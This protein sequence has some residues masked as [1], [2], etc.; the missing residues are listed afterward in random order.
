MTLTPRHRAVAARGGNEC[1]QREEAMIDPTATRSAL[2]KCLSP[3]LFCAAMVPGIIILSGFAMMHV[4]LR[5]TGGG[6]SADL[7]DG[8]LAEWRK[9]T[10]KVRLGLLGWLIF[11]FV[12]WRIL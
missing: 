6:S 4:L 9:D 5:F 1:L 8:I 11:I 12:V 7:E 10:G 2:V 3:L